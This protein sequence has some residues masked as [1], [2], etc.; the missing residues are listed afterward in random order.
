MNAYQAYCL[1]LAIRSHF[2]SNYD[3]FKYGGKVRANPDSFDCRKDKWQFHK[4]SKKRDPLGFLIANAIEDNIKW[5]G[6]TLSE[7]GNSYYEEWLKRTQSLTYLFK[8]QLNALSS[9]FNSN[10]ECK[11]GQHPLLLKK[12]KQGDFTLENLIILD[13]LVHFSSHWNKKITDNI[14]WP[15][16]YK[17]MNNYRPFF[18]YDKENM[19]KILKQHYLS[20]DLI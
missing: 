9:N 8:I 10:F 12:Y 17:L 5:I 4:L 13:D 14:I 2:T 6:D 7:K 16:I 3:Y 1:Y 20:N 11:S 18:S 19:K 15:D